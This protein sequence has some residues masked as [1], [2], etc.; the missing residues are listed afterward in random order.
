MDARLGLLDW[1]FSSLL[2]S[3]DDLFLERVSARIERGRPTALVLENFAPIKG[4]ETALR[5]RDLAIALA[6][7]RKIGLCQ[8][9]QKIVQG[10]L[11]PGTK[12]EIAR[13][14]VQR[15]PELR[16]RVPRERTRWSTEDER[17]H[18]FD[19]LAL[20]VV[21]MRPSAEHDLA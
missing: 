3:D 2:A 9:S 12:A 19:A 17:M 4:R 13:V 8:V 18:I 6:A 5:R 7:Q 15:F 21:V 1:G 20:A 11:G 10:I 14:L 16:H